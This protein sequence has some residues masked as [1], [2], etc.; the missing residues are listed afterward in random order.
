MRIELMYTACSAPE[1]PVL[2]LPKPFPGSFGAL[3]LPRKTLR[4]GES[5][6]SAVFA[7]AAKIMQQIGVP[8]ALA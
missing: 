7:T 5:R 4:L 8:L 3:R 1:T 6:E 2:G